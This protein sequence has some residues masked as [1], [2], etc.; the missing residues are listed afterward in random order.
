MN[1]QRIIFCCGLA[2]I[3]HVLGYLGQ[4]IVIFMSLRWHWTL[5]PVVD[6]HVR[7]P[8]G[9]LLQ[10]RIVSCPHVL[11]IHPFWQVR[12]ACFFLGGVENT[13]FCLLNTALF[14]KCFKYNRS[15]FGGS[16]PQAPIQ[17]KCAFYRLNSQLGTALITLF[18]V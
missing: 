1:Q 11:D 10:C 12:F 14:P 6:G 3:D 2:T 18:F 7:C 8:E 16:N 4:S 5:L 15:Q 17:M 13:F 9:I